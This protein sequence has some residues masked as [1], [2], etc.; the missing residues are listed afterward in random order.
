CR[1]SGFNNTGLIAASG[2]ARAASAWTH[3]ARPI[4]AASPESGPQLMTVELFDMFCALNGATERPRRAKARHSPVV[5]RLLPAF[6]AV[7]ATK[8]DARRVIDPHP[9]RAAIRSRRRR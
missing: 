8:S 7:P 9:E 4:S 6:E 3:C 5:I 2:A 1:L